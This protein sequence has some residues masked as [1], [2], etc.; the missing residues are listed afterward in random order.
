MTKEKDQMIAVRLTAE[1]LEELDAWRAGLTVPPT[2][3]DA[4]RYLIKL[5]LDNAKGK[6]R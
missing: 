2:R 5:G 1:L 4:V 3:S 6:K